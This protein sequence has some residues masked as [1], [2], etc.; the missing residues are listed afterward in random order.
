[1]QGVT[2]KG[3][4]LGVLENKRSLSV[5]FDSLASSKGIAII[6]LNPQK[7]VITAHGKRTV[8]RKIP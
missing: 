7:V 6:N 1:M 5:V 3:I 8:K 4:R 2:G